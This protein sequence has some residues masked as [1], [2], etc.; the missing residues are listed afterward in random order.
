MPEPM[1]FLGCPFH[2]SLLEDKGGGGQGVWAWS[3][4]SSEGAATFQSGTVE[5]TQAD[6]EAACKS[7]IAAFMHEAQLKSSCAV[8]DSP[9]RPGP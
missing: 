6:A 9:P 2:V 8:A 1:R 5:G 3:F 4:C 7:A